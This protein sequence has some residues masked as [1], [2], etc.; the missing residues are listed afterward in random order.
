MPALG[1][2][3]HERG[4]QFGIYSSA[5]FKTCEGRPASLGCAAF[6]AALKRRIL[7]LSS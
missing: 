7:A 6:L 4:L 2:F 3:L 1:R 5:G